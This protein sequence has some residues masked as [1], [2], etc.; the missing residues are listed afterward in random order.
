MRYFQPYRQTVIGFVVVALCVA[1]LIVA[2][3]WLVGGGTR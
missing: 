1:V 2:V 3:Q